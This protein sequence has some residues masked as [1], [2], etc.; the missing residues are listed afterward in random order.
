MFQTKVLTQVIDSSNPAV[1]YLSVTDVK[2]MSH[3]NE[4]FSRSSCISD[5]LRSHAAL[6]SG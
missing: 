3:L 1:D 2:H 4:F 6:N 5:A